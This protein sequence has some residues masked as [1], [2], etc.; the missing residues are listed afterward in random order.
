MRALRASQVDHAE[1]ADERFRRAGF[2]RGGAL[3]D[4]VFLTEENA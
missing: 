1:R 3:S 2:R 4:G